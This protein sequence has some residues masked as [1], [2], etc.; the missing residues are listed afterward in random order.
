MYR[1]INKALVHRF[2]YNQTCNLGSW[3]SQ[4]WHFYTSVK[5]KE[6]KCLLPDQAGGI[7]E[8]FGVTL[9]S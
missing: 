1:F 2:N 7:W 3:V 5:E 4:S 9:S 8:R 6:K